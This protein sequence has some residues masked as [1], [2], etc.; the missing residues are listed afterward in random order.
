MPARQVGGRA[1]AGVEERPQPGE[2]ADHVGA[3]QVVGERRGDH[4]EQEPDLGLGGL[5]YVRDRA[6]GGLVGE[7]DVDRAVG[8]RQHQHEPAGRAGHRRGDG[9]L[10]SGQGVGP[11]HQVGAAAGPERHVGVELAGPDAGRVD[12]GA[13]GDRR[14]RRRSGRRA[15]RRRCRSRA[16]DGGAGADLGT[17]AGGGPGDRGDQPG[18]VLELAVPGEQPSAQPGAAERGRQGERLGRGDPARP[19]AASRARSG[20]RGAA[21]RRRRSRS[22]PAPPGAR[23]RSSVSGSSIGSRVGEVGRGGLHQDPALD[24]RLVGDA[25]PGRARGSAARRGRACSTSATCRTR[26]RG[27]RPP[28]PTGRG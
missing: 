4:V 5:R 21:G 13:G 8:L 17:E 26:G 7:A 1:A 14:P 22:G 2:G 10:Q 24:G 15:A 19:R 12:D 9:G 18:V 20:R 6:V 27:R 11:E 3:A 23:T 16:H 25:R 28:A